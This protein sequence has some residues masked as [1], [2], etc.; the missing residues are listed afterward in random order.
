[1][2][3]TKSTTALSKKPKAKPCT[4]CGRRT[5]AMKEEEEYDRWFNDPVFN[6]RLRM[7]DCDIVLD[8]IRKDEILIAYFRPDKS[9]DR[10][11]YWYNRPTQD[12]VIEALKKA[13]EGLHPD[14]IWRTARDEGIFWLNHREN[15]IETLKDVAFYILTKESGPFT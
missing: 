10:H 6:L 3:K 1:M 12:K 13:M 5:K 4:T 11:H 15:E 9:L 8:R 7:P 14:T 2:D